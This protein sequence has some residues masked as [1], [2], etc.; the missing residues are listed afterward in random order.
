MHPFTITHRRR[1]GCVTPGIRGD[2]TV[3]SMRMES[4]ESSNSGTTWVHADVLKRID[5]LESRRSRYWA[6]TCVCNTRLFTSAFG[7]PISL[8]TV[9]V[10]VVGMKGASGFPAAGESRKKGLQLR[11]VR[12][13]ISDQG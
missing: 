11:D 13:I 1:D 9:F 12:V 8:E 7:Y 10:R 5:R 3:K 2:P 6:R 4:P